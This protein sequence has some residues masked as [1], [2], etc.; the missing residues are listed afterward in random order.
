MKKNNYFSTSKLQL[1]MML[2]AM[3]LLVSCGDSSKKNRS[4]DDDDETE[5]LQEDEDV[6]EDID[7]D[8]DEDAD[9]E[10]MNEA[11]NDGRPTVSKLFDVLYAACINNDVESLNESLTEYGFELSPEVHQNFEG[12]EYI[13]FINASIGDIDVGANED[14]GFY[15]H[16]IPSDA[17]NWSENYF[18]EEAKS[19][20]YE[21]DESEYTN[22]I[23]TIKWQ[24]DGFLMY[25]NN[26]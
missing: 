2:L 22:G 8:F 25:K 11:F 24:V 1:F 9:V 20:G 19:R 18:F 10:E 13:S 15:I 17:E 23:V 6:D 16:Y 4:D 3:V 12:E 21:G 5:V 26:D 14:T 7:E